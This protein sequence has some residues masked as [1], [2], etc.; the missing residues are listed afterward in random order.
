[1]KMSEITLWSANETAKKIASKEVSV[2]EVTAAHLAQIEALNPNLNLIVDHATDAMSEAAAMDQAGPGSDQPLFGVPVTTKINTDQAGFANTNGVPAFADNICKEDSAVVANLKAAGALVIGRTNT[3]EFSL[4]WCTSNPLHGVSLN[5]WDQSATPGGS[6]GAAAAAVS[7]GI[8]AIAHG[9]D[10]GGSLRYPAFCCGV[11]TIRPSMGRIPA[12]NPSALVERP[13][14]TQ[15]MSVQGPIARSI[16]DVRSGL[17]VMARRSARDPLWHSAKDSGRLLGDAIKVGYSRNP[18]AVDISDPAIE[19]AMDTAVKGLS[20]AGVNVV[21]MALPGADRAAQLWGEL[22]FTECDIMLREPIEKHGSPEM[23]RLVAEY[24]RYYGYLDLPGFVKGMAERIALQRQISQMFEGVDFFLMPTSLI[25][26]FEND[27]DFKE[28]S[29]TAAIID[30][31]KPLHVVNLLG[32]PAVSVPTNVVDGL[33]VGVQIMA[34]MHDDWAALDVAELL[35]REI[36]T[37]W[38]ENP[39]FKQA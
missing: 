15:T 18:F 11:A 22:L 39:L 31:Q 26:P 37:I 25:R 35:E 8:G 20:S 32:L 27:L 33:P 10:L 34:P 16:A 9:N 29:K 7:V 14:L 6:S 21:E 4:R 3:P 12:F 2:R 28:P 30:A 38:Q 1:M 24:Q 13:P 19:K 36:G 23:Q 5:P 17:K